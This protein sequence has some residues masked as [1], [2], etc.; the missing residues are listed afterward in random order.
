MQ[1][2]V[3][4]LGGG[5]AGVWAA[6]AAAQARL[7]A[8][9]PS[10]SIVL[11]SDG[12]DLVIRP[13]LYEDDPASMRVSLDHVL[14]PIGVARVAATVE[15]IDAVH[16]RVG[17]R[18]HSG[19]QQSLPFARLVVATGS[20]LAAAAS[21]ESSQAQVHNVDT[22]AAAVALDEHV[23][24]LSSLPSA[25]GRYTAVVVGAGFTGIEIATELVGRL[26]RVAGE[27]ATD[28]RVVLV[29]RQ[30]A[31]GPELGPG[32][33]PVI[34]A[35]LLEL[36]VDYRLGTSVS[37]IRA[38]RVVLDD[39]SQIQ[40]STV[41]W[42]VGMKASP[43]V[44]DLG[45]PRDRLGRVAVDSE[46][47]IVGVRHVLAAGDVAAFDSAGHV[48]P[49]SCQYAIP[50]GECAGYNAAADVLGL[51]PRQFEPRPYVTCLDLGHAGAVFTTGW[52][53]AVQET[54]EVAKMIKKRINTE[55]IYP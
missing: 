21:P 23:Q 29:E 25:P 20:R 38:N 48:L 37:Q 6:K 45:V 43:L 10:M 27:D 9:G 28:A 35:A 51:T 44:G 22:L 7:D 32:P 53:R 15:T 30:E 52:E 55:M 24:G 5:F 17:I 42:T 46:L 54:G 33:R 34:E 11:V 39:G 1:P 41:V 16:Q 18:F 31:L 8:D 4:I 26:R 19:E 50:L 2:D 12:D 49:Q 40:A 13:R 47:R 3:L 14:Q 36:G